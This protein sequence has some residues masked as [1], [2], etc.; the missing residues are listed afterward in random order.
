[1]GK[2]GRM[3]GRMARH[4]AKS[5]QFPSVLSVAPISDSFSVRNLGLD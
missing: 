3:A 2:V 1:M 4:E 5:K